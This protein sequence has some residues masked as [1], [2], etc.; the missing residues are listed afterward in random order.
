MQ[1]IG[2]FFTC[3]AAVRCIYRR[4]HHVLI[5]VGQNGE[6]SYAVAIL[7]NSGL[8]AMPLSPRIRLLLSVLMR[9]WG[10]GQRPGP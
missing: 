5:I 1:R 7:H 6:R 8:I 10:H 2:C 4:N 3:A 9:G